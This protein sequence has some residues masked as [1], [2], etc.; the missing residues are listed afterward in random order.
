[1]YTLKLHIYWRKLLFYYKL[2]LLS[3][4]SIHKYIILFHIST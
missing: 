3:G 2:Q 4:T 1:M